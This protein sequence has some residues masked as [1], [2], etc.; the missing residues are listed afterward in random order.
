MLWVF[1]YQKIVLGSDDVS[2]LQKTLRSFRKE[3]K[4]SGKGL[5]RAPSLA[6]LG[7]STRKVHH[8]PPRLWP[9]NWSVHPNAPKGWLTHRAPSPKLLTQEVW[10]GASEIVLL[11]ASQV[12]LVPLA[13]KPLLQN[14]DLGSRCSVGLAEGLSQLEVRGGLLSHFSFSS[15]AQDPQWCHPTVPWLLS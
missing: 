15:N 8:Q 1:Y 9:S 14:T 3:G 4:E 5:Q 2:S 12:L 13:Y 10:V 11:T 6:G 7:N